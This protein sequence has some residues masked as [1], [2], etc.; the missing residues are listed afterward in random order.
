MLN[1]E[2]LFSEAETKNEV[3]TFAHFEKVVFFSENGTFAVF[4]IF[5]S[6]ESIC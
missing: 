4:R 5:R 6:E 1:L 2:K 3:E